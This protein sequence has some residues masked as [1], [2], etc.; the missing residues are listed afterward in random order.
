[1]N[2]LSAAQLGAMMASLIV[3]TFLALWYFVPWASRSTRRNSLLV[4]LWLHVPRYITLIMYS[5]QHDG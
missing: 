4:L 5:A 2:Y 3:S 1:M